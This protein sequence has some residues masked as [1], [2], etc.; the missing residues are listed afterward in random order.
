MEILRDGGQVYSYSY[1][2]SERNSYTPRERERGGE[3]MLLHV[4]GFF[5]IRIGSTWPFRASVGG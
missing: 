2:E 1:T 4:A 5:L 3:V